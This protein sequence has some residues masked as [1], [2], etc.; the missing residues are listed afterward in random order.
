MCIC[1]KFPISRA[2]AVKILNRALE[3]ETGRNTEASMPFSDV[4]ENHWAYE[5]ILAASQSYDPNASALR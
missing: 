3:R 1:F 4:P 5:E 2:E